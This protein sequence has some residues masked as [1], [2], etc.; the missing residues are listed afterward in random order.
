MRTIYI[1]YLGELI[2]NFQPFDLPKCVH[3]CQ[4]VVLI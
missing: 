4:D 1:D 3:T 2:L